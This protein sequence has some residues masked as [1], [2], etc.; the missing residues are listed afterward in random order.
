MLILLKK[1]L[2]EINLETTNF[3]R[4][5][6]V[7][8]A[9]Y[10][11]SLLL[12][13]SYALQ[14][15]GLLEGYSAAEA[16]VLK[17]TSSFPSPFEHFLYWPYYLCVYLG[18]L[19]IG[20]GLMAARLT[21][22]FAATLA[23]V[24]FLFILRRQFGFFLSLVGVSLLAFNSWFLQL[25]R[26]GTGEMFALSGLIVL[27]AA[28]LYTR[29]HPKRPFKAASLGMTAFCWF[30]PLAGWL[31]SALSIHAL[32]V[33]KIIKRSIGVRLKLAIVL[34]I[35][36][37]G[38][39]MFLAFQAEQQN[40]FIAWGIPE[41]ITNPQNILDN[42]LKTLQALVWRAPY[43]PQAWLAQTPVL[44]VFTA[45]LL[46][47]GLYA[48]F[49]KPRSVE[50]YYFAFCCLVIIAVASLNLGLPT[51]GAEL[52]LPLIIFLSLA[53]L[54]Q[55]FSIWQKTFPLNP[56]AKALSILVVS[57]LVSTSLFYQAHRYFV[58]WSKYPQTQEI[59][60]LKPQKD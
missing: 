49:K 52:I 29:A 36:A 23:A 51:T 47:F 19:I 4:W 6:L 54:Q 33:H 31:I 9:V 57:V 12:M 43:N 27:V 50:Y 56:L 22:N 58:A 15:G 26:A 41:T 35:M 3:K 55:L 2:Y 46:P 16:E 44:D 53:G 59:Y 39:V 13:F 17:A 48:A 34:G 30:M 40:V 10:F 60:N 8:Y 38:A 25:A 42:L 32:Y 11:L 24:G 21:S 14:I 7:F 1:I 37:F 28:L 45:A 5:L 20:D 18:R